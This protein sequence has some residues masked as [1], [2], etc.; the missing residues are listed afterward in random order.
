PQQADE[1]QK[2]VDE[3]AAE[4]DEVTEYI[5]NLEARDEEGELRETSG[6]VIARE[7]ERYLRR[8][9]RGGG[10]GG[11]STGPGGPTTH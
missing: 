5:R 6:D 7:F 4:D 1:W 10:F 11:G 2:L 3:M 9:D 8:R